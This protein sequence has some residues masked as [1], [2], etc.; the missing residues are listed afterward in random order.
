MDGSHQLAERNYKDFGKQNDRLYRFVCYIW[1]AYKYI[2]G[3]KNE[4]K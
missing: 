3:E 4:K 1:I 2:L